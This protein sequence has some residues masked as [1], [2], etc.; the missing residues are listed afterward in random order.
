MENSGGK[1]SAFIWAHRNVT[2]PKPSYHKTFILSNLQTLLAQTPYTTHIK[3]CQVSIKPSKP[4][5]MFSMNLEKFSNFVIK[6]YKI[7][8]RFE[9]VW[10]KSEKGLKGLI[11]YILGG[12]VVALLSPLKKAAALVQCLYWVKNG[13]GESK[14]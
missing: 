10:I 1:W 11:V 9:K 13:G 6:F 5:K 3:V 2:R 7:F 12:L 14:C 8:K 4:Y